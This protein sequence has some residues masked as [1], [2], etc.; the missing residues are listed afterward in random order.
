MIGVGDP[1]SPYRESLEHRELLEYR[2]AELRRENARLKADLESVRRRQRRRG[3]ILALTLCL[4]VVPAAGCSGCL[5][6]LN[7]SLE[8]G[9]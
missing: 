1:L 2:V 8:G 9:R 5:V 3:V 7:H 4:T 6:G